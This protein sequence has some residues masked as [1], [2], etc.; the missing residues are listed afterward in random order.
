MGVQEVEATVEIEAPLER[1]RGLLA[2]FGAWG[3]W[4]D[5]VVRVEGA[6]AP[7]LG[8]RV[9]LE[10]RW[11]DGSSTFADEIISRLEEEP[12]RWCYCWDYVSLPNRLGLLRASRIFEVRALDAGRCSF[13][14]HERFDGLITPF[15]PMAKIRAGFLSMGAALKR[16]AERP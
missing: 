13:H 6:P 3:A 14:S 1:V 4:N 15:L 2:D 12:G 11:A 7:A 10:V 16:A 5:W 8:A 9:R